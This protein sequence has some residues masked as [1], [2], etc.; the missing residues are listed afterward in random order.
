MSGTAAGVEEGG[1][2][3]TGTAGSGRGGGAARRRRDRRDREAERARARSGRRTAVLRHGGGVVELT[4][5]MS[6]VSGLSR[7]ANASMW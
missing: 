6:L 3:R 2:R 7:E 5:Q 1:R 4:R